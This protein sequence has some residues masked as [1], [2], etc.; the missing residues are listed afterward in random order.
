ME[1]FTHIT[2][3]ISRRNRHCVIIHLAQET[4]YISSVQNR[5]VKR[6]DIG[7]CSY[8]RDKRTVGKTTVIA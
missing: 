1:F 8:L 3:E 5:A 6:N 4:T 7:F 2:I